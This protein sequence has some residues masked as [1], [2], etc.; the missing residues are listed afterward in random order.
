MMASKDGED[1]T[2]SVVFTTFSKSFIALCA[3]RQ[4]TSSITGE[5]Q[6]DAVTKVEKWSPTIAVGGCGNL[7]V[8]ETVLDAVKGYLKENHPTD[9]TLEEIADLFGQ[10]YYAACDEFEEYSSDSMLSE[11][12]I[13]GELSDGEFGV[14]RVT[15]R[16]GAAESDTFEAKE[17]PGT[18]ICEPPDVSNEECNDLLRKAI[19]NTKSQKKLYHDLMETAHRKAVRYVSERSKFVGHKSDY[20]LLTK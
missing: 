6:I 20:V 12:V 14:V 9:I 4:R 17:T 15:L 1:D 10:A 19:L 13:A 18:I 16:G 3:D 5:V 11:F 2:M 7:A 8:C